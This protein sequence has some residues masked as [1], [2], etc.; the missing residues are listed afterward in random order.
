M[1]HRFLAAAAQGDALHHF[2]VVN[3]GVMEQV[4]PVAVAALFREAPLSEYDPF[5]HTAHEAA[6]ALQYVPA[7]HASFAIG[8][9]FINNTVFPC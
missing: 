5:Q 6:P 1:E 3:L 2:D 4:V 9:N 7:M 8:H